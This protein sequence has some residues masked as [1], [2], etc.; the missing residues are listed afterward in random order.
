M[1]Q[2]KNRVPYEGSDM[3]LLVASYVG[4]EEPPFQ[5]YSQYARSW[6][7]P[8]DSPRSTWRAFLAV[9]SRPAFRD[10]PCWLAA[11]LTC[12]CEPRLPIF[13]S[14]AAEGRMLVKPGHNS[15]SARVVRRGS[16]CQGVRLPNPC[17]ELQI[18]ESRSKVFVFWVPK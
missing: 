12:T 13:G 8:Y 1:S 2:P 5:R 17:L 15:C 14:P 7:E 3:S 9:G 4:Q 6:L 16:R 10:E 18:A 11:A